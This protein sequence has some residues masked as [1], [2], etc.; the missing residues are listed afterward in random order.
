VGAEDFLGSA[1]FDHRGRDE[2]ASQFTVAGL[3]QLDRVDSRHVSA[4]MTGNRVSFK[5]KPGGVGSIYED[6]R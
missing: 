3:L 2:D 5:E 1:G 6:L 4:S